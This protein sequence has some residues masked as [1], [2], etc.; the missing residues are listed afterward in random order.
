MC[1]LLRKAYPVYFHCVTVSEYECLEAIIDNVL[2]CVCS[3]RASSKLAHL[4]VATTAEIVLRPNTDPCG[5]PHVTS[6]VHPAETV[7]TLFSKYLP[8]ILYKYGGID[9]FCSSFR[10]PSHW[11]ELKTFS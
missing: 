4:D 7:N 8:T 2:L 9:L 10:S 3:A 1:H 11:A 6:K 5:T